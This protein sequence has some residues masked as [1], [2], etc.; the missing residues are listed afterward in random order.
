[1]L[2]GDK[3][4]VDPMSFKLIE[5][6]S[7]LFYDGFWGDTLYRWNKKLQKTSESSLVN[8]VDG[9]WRRFCLRR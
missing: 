6:K 3:V 7:Y 1:M 9:H 8:E 2:D 5:G 4:E